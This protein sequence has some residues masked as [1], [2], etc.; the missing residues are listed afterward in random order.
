MRKLIGCRIP[1]V[2]PLKPNDNGIYFT[3]ESL[4]YIEED[5]KNA[6]IIQDGKAIGILTDN[7]NAFKSEEQITLF[8]D[9]QLYIE[10]NPE[11]NIIDVEHNE[12]IHLIKS[13]R[14]SSVSCK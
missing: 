6:P 8:V 9:G 4:N 10:C 12:D 1:I 3:E 13:F 2:F 7:F 14:L 11:I 5:L